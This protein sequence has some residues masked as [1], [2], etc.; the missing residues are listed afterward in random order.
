M[1]TMKREGRKAALLV[2]D[3]QNYFLD[4]G[5]PSYLAGSRRI[6]PRI[7]RLAAAAGSAG[8]PVVF[9]AHRSPSKPGNMMAERYQR[10]PAGDECRLWRGIRRP[11]GSVLLGK[12]HYSAFQATGLA[13]RL[14]RLRVQE[15]LLCGVMTHLCVDTTARHGFMLG[16]KPT[17]IGDACCSKDRAYHRAALL[18]LEHGFADIATTE[19]VIKNVLGC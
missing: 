16:F 4:P 2:I 6:V 13:T 19:E 14:R 1:K 7:N 17:V 5:S 9:T 11:K 18:A 3:C 10:L 12:E 8:M 15:I